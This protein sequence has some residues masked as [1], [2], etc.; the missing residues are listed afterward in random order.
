MVVWSSS[1]SPVS[2]VFGGHEH[3]HREVKI[4][5]SPKKGFV[6]MHI[7][8]NLIL[9]WLFLILVVFY[10]QGRVTERVKRSTLRRRVLVLE[11]GRLRMSMKVRKLGT[12]I[13]KLCL[14]RV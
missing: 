10:E 9:I 4:A 11:R 3:D 8:C 2:D 7:T 12:E 14:Q 5:V 6:F 13:Q 1:A